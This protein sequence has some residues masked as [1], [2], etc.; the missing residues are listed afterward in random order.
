MSTASKAARRIHCRAVVVGL[1]VIVPACCAPRDSRHLPEDVISELSGIA[2]VLAR[3]HGFPAGPE[4]RRGRSST[5][6]PIDFGCA[7]PEDFLPDSGWIREGLS[8]GTSDVV[9]FDPE[10]RDR[11]P[12][13]E[14]ARACWRLEQMG[15]TGL[16]RDQ[17]DRIQSDHGLVAAARCQA[18]RALGA[19]GDAAAV[20]RLVEV[21]GDD[22]VGAEALRSLSRAGP[23]VLAGVRRAGLPESAL[24]SSR[25]AWLLGRHPEDLGTSEI[26]WL[27]QGLV[28][29]SPSGPLWALA[30]IHERQAERVI[31]FI[32]PMLQQQ[33]AAV[34]PWALLAC[35]R[36][37]H[38]AV[39]KLAVEMARTGAGVH[40]LLA[41]QYLGRIE[42][43]EARRVVVDLVRDQ[44]AAV[45]DRAAAAHALACYR[46]ERSDT[47]ADLASLLDAVDI[48]LV[49]AGL[50]ALSKMDP[51][52]EPVLKRV[53]ALASS[54]DRD[55]RFLVWCAGVAR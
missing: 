6:H 32:L 50:S 29:A 5:G 27:A 47:L 7:L 33:D 1:C 2:D 38:P 30:R 53:N 42:S 15:C 11:V 12:K 14:V 41:L 39:E 26:R 46:T 18:V 55:V 45:P 37:R 24:A 36:V 17:L 21:L 10:D 20:T 40:R 23:I 54:D 4:S 3:P 22:I 16:L 48:R 49:R 25:V 8:T 31:D 44:S 19:I 9:A 28:G 13:N 43:P 52:P 34:G 35:A 51:L